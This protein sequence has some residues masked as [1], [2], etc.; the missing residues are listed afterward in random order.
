MAQHDH[1]DLSTLAEVE[2]LLTSTDFASV[3]DLARRGVATTGLPRA[4]VPSRGADQ[5]LAADAAPLPKRR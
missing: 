2:R 3:D 5:P 1:I 4:A